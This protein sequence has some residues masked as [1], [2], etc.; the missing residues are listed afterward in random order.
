MGNAPRPPEAFPFDPIDALDRV[1]KVLVTASAPIAG[2]EAV[3]A[4]D[5]TYASLGV[6]VA[7]LNPV[8]GATFTEHG[9]DLRIAE[10]V[11]WYESRGVPFSWWLGPTSEPADL[12]DRLVRHDFVLEEESLPGMAAVLA[13]LPAPAPPIGSTIERVADATTFRTFCDVLAAGFGV[14]QD[15]ADAFFRLVGVGFGND[16]AFRHYLARLDGRPVA[17]T[18]GVVAGDTL[19]IYNVATVPEARGNGIGRQIT[20]AAME[21]G[22]AAGCAL[23]VLEASEMG[24]C[25]YERLGFRAF[26]EY[27]VYVRSTGG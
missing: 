25:V 6:Q 8:F 11:A 22:A 24:R 9:A 13:D 5:V 3:L 15:F 19:G 14:S 12:A 21:D 7:V 2:S 1:N 10:I 18:T 23:A 27:Q 26:G 20:L 16:V 4:P 17:T